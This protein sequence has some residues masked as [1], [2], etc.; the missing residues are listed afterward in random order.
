MK[1]DEYQ[2]RMLELKLDH[3]LNLLSEHET[4]DRERKQYENL[5]EW[6][7]L[8]TAAGLKG[9]A[10]LATYK[11]KL[12]LQPCCG[13]NY[14]LVGGRKCWLRADVIAWIKITDSDLKKYADIWKVKI[15]SNYAARVA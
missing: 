9:G 15:P 10:A 14:R 3:I 6:V 4:A 11:T 2:L 7:N 13:R 12:F 1:E 5:P 8:E